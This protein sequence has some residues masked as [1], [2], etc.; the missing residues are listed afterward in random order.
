MGQVL[1]MM[2]QFNP[3]NY[4]MGIAITPNLHM[5]NLRFTGFRNLPEGSEP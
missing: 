3:Y 2:I 5:R 1:L 4:K